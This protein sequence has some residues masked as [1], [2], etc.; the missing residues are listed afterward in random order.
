MVRHQ[1]LVDA[2]RHRRRRIADQLAKRGGKAR[3]DPLD[4]LRLAQSR[5]AD[6]V[7]PAIAIVD[8]LQERDGERQRALAI[9]GGDG[10]L[11]RFEAGRTDRRRHRA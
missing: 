6:R 2:R 4:A 11:E 7:E 8:R 1:L 10:K 3:G 5:T 9:A